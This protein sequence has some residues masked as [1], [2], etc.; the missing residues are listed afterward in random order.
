MPVD[1]G[2]LSANLNLPIEQ[3]VQIKT[4][5]DAERSKLG[6]AYAAMRNQESQAMAGNAM[7]RIQ[8]SNAQNAAMQMQREKIQAEQGMKADE[9]AQRSEEAQLPYNQITQGQ[10]I[11]QM[12]YQDA[13]RAR[14][15]KQAEDQRDYQRNL[16]ND[17]AK[18]KYEMAKLSFDQNKPESP[19]AK[20][21]Y[22]LARE[23]DPVKRQMLI[24]QRNLQMAQKNET[25]TTNKDGTTTISRGTN[26][27]QGG[28][29]FNNKVQEEQLKS[30]QQLSDLKTIRDTWKPSY[31]TTTGQLGEKLKGFVAGKGGESLLTK[32]QKEDYANYTNWK[33]NLEQN[34]LKYKVE[35]TGAAAS[36]SEMDKIQQSIFSSK[37]DPIAFKAAMD[38]A[39]NKLKRYTAIRQQALANGL[40]PGTKP[41]AQFVDQSGWANPTPTDHAKA[42]S[43][44]EIKE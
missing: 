13:E 12:G 14:L 41:Y 10:R 9:L 25:I 33:K 38:Q 34:F 18:Q 3:M 30:D 40:Q 27:G 35:V 31:S 1:Y 42:L 28:S 6:L 11:Q 16:A 4:Q 32:D 26:A 21:A 43:R 15:V 19:E 44:F 17:A 8:A 36:N 37:D 7:Q 20:F 24:D 5:Q 39:E 29:G 23:Q 2:L 22:D